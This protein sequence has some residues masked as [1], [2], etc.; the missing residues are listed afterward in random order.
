MMKK[1]KINHRNQ[2]GIPAQKIHL[3][4]VLALSVCLFDI[5]RMITQKLHNRLPLNFMNGCGTGQ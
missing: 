3:H 1:T 4:Q 5:V 2:K